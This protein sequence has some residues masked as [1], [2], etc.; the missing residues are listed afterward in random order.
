MLKPWAQTHVLR[1]RATPNTGN[2]SFIVKDSFDI[3]SSALGAPVQGT[4]LGN[5]QILCG[6][7]AST[8]YLGR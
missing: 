4:V 3:R 8:Y 1:P 2:G 6:N 5:D 7:I